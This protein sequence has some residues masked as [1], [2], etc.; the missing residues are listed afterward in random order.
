MSCG[1][2]VVQKDTF[3]YDGIYRAVVVSTSDPDQVGRIKVRVYGIFGDSMKAADLP[4]AVPAH[5]IFSGSGSGYGQ[6]AVPEVGSQVFV[7]FE[8]NDIYQP[9][10]FAEAPTKVHGQPTERTT[11]YPT[12]KIL[13]TKNGIVVYIDDTDKVIRID[14]PSGKSIQMD[15]SGNITIVG[16]NVTVQASGNANVTAGGSANLTASGTVTIQG[17][18][19][20]IN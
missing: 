14:H 5:P 16:A 17:S 9:V 18:Q 4:W 12:R 20:D 8:G 2:G 3:A 7:F 13:R 15:G 11:N 19:V 10:Y 1:N 6:W